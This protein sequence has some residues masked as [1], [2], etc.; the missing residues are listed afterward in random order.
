MTCYD[1][2][3]FE[4]WVRSILK[5]HKDLELLENMNGL[6]TLYMERAVG[7]L[8]KELGP[9]ATQGVL[10]IQMNMLYA[11]AAK[12]RIPYFLRK[13]GYSSSAVNRFPHCPGIYTREQ[14]EAWKKVVDAVH[15]K[16]SIIF[17][18]LWH[19]GRASNP[20][21]QPQ[22]AAP[23]SG[24]WKILM[25]DG[26]YGKYLKPRRLA[27]AEI[28]DIVQQYRQAALN[29]IEAEIPDIV[30]AFPIIVMFGMCSIFLFMASILQRRLM[31]IADRPKSK[32]QD[33]TAL[34]EMVGEEEPL[35]V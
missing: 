16:G 21:Y 4:E 29:A 7:E 13:I 5:A 1:A 20:V 30:N 3:L 33:W 32:P 10:D 23:I 24:R 22:G 2:E 25:P 15:A 34:R 31:V 11:M 17:C 6:Y 35:Y 19:V 14:V 8:A 26:S 18:Q 27:T 9:V 12:V 28:P